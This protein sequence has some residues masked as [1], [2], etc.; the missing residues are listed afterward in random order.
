MV[1][2]I[3]DELTERV[4]GLPALPEIVSR[5]AS[6][7]VEETSARE[8]A[9]IIEKD[10]AIS[11]R[12]LKISNSAYFGLTGDVTTV[13]MAATV[14]GVRPVKNM[15]LCSSM[16]DLFPSKSFAA[17]G[18]GLHWQYNC[19][20]ATTNRILAKITKY[21]DPDEAFTAGLLQHIGLLF[22]LTMN[23]EH[24][25]KVL[26]ESPENDFATPEL[27]RSILGTDHTEAGLILGKHLGIPDILLAP[28]RYHHE[29]ENLPQNMVKTATH[30]VRLNACS[31]MIAQIFVLPEKANLLD[32]L[33][34]KATEWFDIDRQAVADAMGTMANEVGEVVRSFLLDISP[35]KNY[36]QVLQEANIE[37]AREALRLMGC[38]KDEEPEKMPD[39][40]SSEGEPL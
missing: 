38:D 18:F 17:G 3:I 39:E 15:V 12:L 4:R 33:F 27:E 35:P 23:P 6:V 7:K 24:Y 21:P 22:L 5:V 9:R 29:P 11:A 1:K 28:V 30:L 16:M 25:D 2:S 37:L 40:H 32:R 31:D 19:T 14:L 20:V 36:I 13:R 10:S 34:E 26:A 8:M